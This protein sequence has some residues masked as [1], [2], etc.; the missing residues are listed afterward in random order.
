MLAQWD[1]GSVGAFVQRMNE[2]ARALGMTQ[3][4]YADTSGIAPGSAGS[5]ADQLVLAQVAM[6]NPVFAEIV[7]M[8]ETTL[9]FAGTMHSTNQ[10]LGTDGVVGIKTGNTD[11][12]G[13][14]FIIALDREV[15]G[16]PFQVI[17]VALG[18]PALEDAFAAAHVLADAVADAMHPVVVLPR[19]APVARLTSAW[20]ASSSAVTAEDVTVVG[21][22][23]MPL[24]VTAELVPLQAPLD[25]GAE[26]GTLHIDAG[27]RSETAR[28]QAER[29]LGGPSFTWRVFRY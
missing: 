4:T 6:Q 17:G 20:E 14:C 19:G 8:S 15:A 24:T 26:V 22:A 28:L 9:P 21:W 3:T 10:L 27:E 16:V 29:G 7:R 18:Q 2:K 11:E 13:G 25:A 5:A 12:A 1:A 23:G